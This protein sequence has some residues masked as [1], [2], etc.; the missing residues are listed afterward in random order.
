MPTTVVS[1]LNKE[2]LLA[3]SFDTV[4]ILKY[5]D[6]TSG[7]SE[8]LDVVCFSAVSFEVVTVSGVLSVPSRVDKV[9]ASSFPLECSTSSLVVFVHPPVVVAVAATVAAA[10]TSVTVCASYDILPLLAGYS[11]VVNV[12]CAERATV[13]SALFEN[14]DALSSDEKMP[15][16]APDDVTVF[17]A[18]AGLLVK[19]RS[20]SDDLSS[21]CIESVDWTMAECSVVWFTLTSCRSPNK[22][23]PN[24]GVFVARVFFISRDNDADEDVYSTSFV[25]APSASSGDTVDACTLTPISSLGVLTTTDVA[26][27]SEEKSDRNVE[28]FVVP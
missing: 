7:K 24:T 19:N 9:V 17:S 20:G 3:V 18:V 10:T 12:T 11:D 1:M 4:G 8:T 28:D 23:P 15:L 25:V 2:L 21:R 26:A 16:E 13:R 5:D 6:V 22:V 14:D 27:L